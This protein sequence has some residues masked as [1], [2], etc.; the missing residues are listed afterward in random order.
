MLDTTRG[1]PRKG[2][3]ASTSKGENGR[4]ECGEECS[5]YI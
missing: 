4:N 2:G 1:I 3:G 5:S